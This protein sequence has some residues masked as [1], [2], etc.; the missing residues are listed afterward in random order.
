MN[1][2][3]DFCSFKLPPDAYLFSEK[4]HKRESFLLECSKAWCH[5]HTTCQL[6]PFMVFF[7][8]QSSDQQHQT[9]N[10]QILR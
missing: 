10:K 1:F 4:Q 7:P 9:L 3:P 5:G 8:K 6:L 2:P